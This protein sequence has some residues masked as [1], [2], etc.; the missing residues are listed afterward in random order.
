MATP[1]LITDRT[2]SNHKPRTTQYPTT[3]AVR[4]RKGNPVNPGNKRGE[5]PETERLAVAGW[6][7][8]VRRSLVLGRSDRTLLCEGAEM[9]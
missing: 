1:T 7:R 2:C 5:T 8:K 6:I 9:N 3:L 4:E